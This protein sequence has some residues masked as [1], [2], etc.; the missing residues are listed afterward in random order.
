MKTVLFEA[1]SETRPR[2]RSH[3]RLHS[4]EA[5]AEEFI[6]IGPT[7]LTRFI[8]Q[9]LACA[10]VMLLDDDLPDQWVLHYYAGEFADVGSCRF[11]ILVRETMRVRIVR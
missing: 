4:I 2:S 7:E 5:F 8:L 9:I 6:R 3:T 1:R 11:V 10:S